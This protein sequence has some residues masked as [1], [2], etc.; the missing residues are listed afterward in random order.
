MSVFDD[1]AYDHP[2]PDVYNSFIRAYA[3][4]GNVGRA[5]E[6]FE[7]LA[8]PPSGVHAP[9]NHGIDSQTAS[10][11]D[12]DSAHSTGD[13]QLDKPVVYREPSTF[14][15][16]IRCE[17]SA[18]NSDAARALLERAKA[19]AFP[20]AVVARMEKLVRGEEQQ[21]AAQP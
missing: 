6:I 4:A 17:M 5:R 15:A 18:G 9:G 1:F 8:D 10:Q 12:S 14:E 2:F 11:V 13:A 21:Q 19:R 16:M 7:S 20:D 3:G